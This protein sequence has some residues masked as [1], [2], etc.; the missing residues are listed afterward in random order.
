AFVLWVYLRRNE[1]YAR[2]R[3]TII[4][5]DV[6]GV[7][8][9]LLYPTAPPRMLS[10]LGF[11]DT[12]DQTGVNHHSGLIAALANP[13]A[14]MPILHTSYAVTLGVR[15]A[16]L[17]R[18]PWRRGPWACCPAL[19]GFSFVATANHFVLDAIAG[20]GAA[21][22]A[23]TLTLAVERLRLRTPERAPLSAPA[24]AY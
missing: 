4:A 16:L 10:N 21:A 8:G 22:V 24:P 3:N 23:A 14:A 9:Y 1:A 2:L 17:A 6:V 13:Y 19:V 7:I 5:I 18:R 11:V 12:L 15:G 20:A